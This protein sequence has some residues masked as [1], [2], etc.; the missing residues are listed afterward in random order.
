[1]LLILSNTPGDETSPVSMAD[2]RD[3]RDCIQS[4]CS[5]SFDRGTMNSVLEKKIRVPNAN[6]TEPA[7]WRRPSKSRSSNRGLNNKE[8]RV[9]VPDIFLIKF[10]QNVWATREKWVTPHTTEFAQKNQLVAGV[11]LI[12]INNSDCHPVQLIRLPRPHEDPSERALIF[13]LH[14]KPPLH[15]HPIEDMC[16]DTGKHPNQDDALK[17]KSDKKMN[18]DQ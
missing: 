15:H 18:C 17:R 1:M 12:T 7:F 10:L 16:Q 5:A 11:A 6:N 14:T 3:W 13:K 9:A 8:S 2:R 4:R